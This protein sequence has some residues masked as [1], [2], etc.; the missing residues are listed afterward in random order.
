MRK[1]SLIILVISWIV[2]LQ[3]CTTKSSESV[4]RDGIMTKDE[5]TFPKPEKSL[6][7]KSLSVNLENL[8]KVEARMSKDEVRKLIGTPHFPAGLVR[9]VEWDYLFN[10]KEKAGDEDFI[11]QYK[12][13]YDIDAY[14]VASTFW[15]IDE[16]ENFVNQNSKRQN[17]KSQ[18]VLFDFASASLN[19]SEKNKISNLVNKFGKDNIQ[20][21]I[22]VGHTDIIGDEESN[23]ILSQKRA[24]STKNEFIKNGI[25]NSKITTYAIGEKESIKKCDPNLS[26]DELIK[27]LAPNRR[28][29]IDIVTH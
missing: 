22:I 8:R 2:F 29:N 15:N 12:V 23:L 16:C 3:G 24:N 14:K 9:V 25:E 21:T 20:N 5:V 6:Y 10:L 13:V 28:A 19:Q 11:C 18:D 26:K 4:P 17:L 27:C 7:G 1:I